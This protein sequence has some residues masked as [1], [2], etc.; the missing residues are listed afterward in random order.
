MREGSFWIGLAEKL[1][2]IILIILGIL[3]AYFTATSPILGTFTGIFFFVSIVI[4]VAGSL[5][6]V[7][8]PPE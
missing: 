1:F 4:L 2:G 5:L 7:V 6:I 3:L 8:K